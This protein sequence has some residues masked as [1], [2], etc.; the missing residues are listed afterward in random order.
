MFNPVTIAAVQRA[1][2]AQ[3]GLRRSGR[4]LLDMDWRRYSIPALIHVFYS[5]FVMIPTRMLSMP[6][7]QIVIPGHGDTVGSPIIGLRTAHWYAAPWE[8][9]TLPRT[10][11]ALC[12]P[13]APCL[14]QGHTHTPALHLDQPVSVPCIEATRETTTRE[15]GPAALAVAVDPNS[16]SHARDGRTDGLDSSSAS[17]HSGG[18][19][20]S[21]DRSR[22]RVQ[23]YTHPA[24]LAVPALELQS[25]PQMGI[26]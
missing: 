8:V 13:P 6:S 5:C 26:G 10:S 21:I 25:Y 12:S 11:Y 4:V 17:R 18:T 15:A 3:W 2:R 23:R 19:T 16:H 24:S 1:Q 7:L 14:R 20:S 22:G 9:L